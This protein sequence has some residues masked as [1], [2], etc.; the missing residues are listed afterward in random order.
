[1]ATGKANCPPCNKPCRCL[2][3]DGGRIVE[4]MPQVEAPAPVSRIEYIP[5]ERS[6]IEYEVR[7]RIERIPR[8]RKVVEYREEVKID[9]VPVTKEVED[10]Y[11]VEIQKQ[12]VAQYKPK[13]EIQ[14]I[15][16]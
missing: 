7:E 10:F 2:P 15:P 4:E 1:M 14:K 16:V 6:T 8:Q 13:V 11:A 3:C 12:Y 9:H 5:V